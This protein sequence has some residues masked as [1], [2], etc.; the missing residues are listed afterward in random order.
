M[1]YSLPFMMMARIEVKKRTRN[2][3]ETQDVFV[4]SKFDFVS[5]ALTQLEGP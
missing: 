3:L 2:L 4:A 5:Q 1:N